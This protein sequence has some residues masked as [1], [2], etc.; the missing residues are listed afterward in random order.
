MPRLEYAGGAF[1]LG[2]GMEAETI[3][4][5]TS[6]ELCMPGKTLRQLR[7]A[8]DL[9]TRELARR[10][11]LTRHTIRQAERSKSFCLDKQDMSAL[12]EAL[13]VSGFKIE[14]EAK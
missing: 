5:Y 13:G 2:Q 11:G 10:T 3:T 6:D 14:S 1:N 12:L 7:V 9:G 4:L 8:A